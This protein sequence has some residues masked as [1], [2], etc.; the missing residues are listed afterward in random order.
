MKIKINKIFKFDK[1]SKIKANDILNN[2]EDNIKINRRRNVQK[3]DFKLIKKYSILFSCM[4]LLAII[5]LFSG[6]K[7]K[8]EDYQVYESLDNNQ[9]LEVGNFQ[10]N[11][12][13]NID[14]R[15]EETVKKIEEP[16]KTNV[17]VNTKPV[18]KT[19]NKVNEL[20]FIK[21]INGSIL[22]I[23]SI[24]KLIYSNTLETWKI[25]DGIDIKAN[26]N[27]NV[28][29]TEKGII[30]KIYNDSYY[31]STVIIDHGQGYKSIYS[32]VL[33]TL[34][35]KDIVKKSQVIGKVVNDAISEIKDDVHIHYMLMFNN[36]TIDPNS[37][38]KF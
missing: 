31:G 37:K 33:S 24:D 36:E 25:H 16:K 15:N 38:I 35:T 7:S 14:T 23:Y 3:N 1:K 26:L 30:E 8:K 11:K 5:S 12:V 9:T 21:P 22:K 32:N 34:K 6:I 10:D 2:K 19:E 28:Y 17:V 20:K 29:A 18:V 4:T 13:N 27:D